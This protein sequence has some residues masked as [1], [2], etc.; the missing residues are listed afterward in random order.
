MGIATLTLDGMTGRGL[1]G[2]GTDH[3]V[4]GRLNFILDIY[5]SLEVL[6]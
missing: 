4:L 2:V 1:Q 5:R 3:S 6:A